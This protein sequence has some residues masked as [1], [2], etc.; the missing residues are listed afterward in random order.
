VPGPERL[1]D[2][3]SAITRRPLTRRRFLGV[4]GVAGLGA[5]VSTQAWSLP[6]GFRERT[7]ESPRPVFDPDTYR[8][9]VDGLVR[10]PLT[11]TYRQL[12]RLP[13]AQQTCDFLCVERWGVEDVPWEGIQVG[14]LM[15]AV[16]PL[17]EARFVTFHCLGDVYQESLSLEQAQL[18]SALLAYRM[19][20]SPLPPERGSPLRLV[21][22]RML[23]YKGAKWVTRV[24][25]RAERDIGYWG[26]FGLDPW[27]EDEQ[28]CSSSSTCRRSLSRPRPQP[29]QERREPSSATPTPMETPLPTEPAPRGLHRTGRP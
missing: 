5:Y 6:D 11:F 7:V 10:R 29:R 26:R 19:Y 14:T 12:L 22:P 8:L 3:L 13:S 20:G 23:G 2:D 4:L 15:R 24:E 27:V 25:F 28:P 21:F 1:N 9:V 17:A 16:L 18:P